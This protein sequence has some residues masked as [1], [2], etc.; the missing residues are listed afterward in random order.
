MTQV[1]KLAIPVFVLGFIAGAG[2]WYLFSPAFIDRVVSEEL[3]AGLELTES[4]SGSFRDVDGAH[5][6]TGT[7]KVLAN[8]A[9]GTLLRFTEFEVTNGPGLEVWLVE[10]PDP[11]RS[12]DVSASRW[13]SLGPLKGNKGDQTYVVPEGV[14]MTTWGSVAIWCEQLSVLYS[15]ATLSPAGV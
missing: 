5:R 13:L 4:R 14:D 3:P 7:V 9:G 10:N 1:Y 2:F 12:A 6:G 15:V 11:Q 8:A